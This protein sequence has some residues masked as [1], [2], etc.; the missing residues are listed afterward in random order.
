VRPLH[1]P[2]VTDGVVHDEWL[3]GEGL[4]RAITRHRTSRDEL[5]RNALRLS[6]GD[7]AI[8]TVTRSLD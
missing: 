8:P 7:P 3:G 1:V 2:L 6:V 4:S 5:P